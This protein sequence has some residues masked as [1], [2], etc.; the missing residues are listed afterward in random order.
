MGGGWLF[1]F[2]RYFVERKAE[3][4]VCLK[5]SVSCWAF[6]AILFR[7]SQRIECSSLVWHQKWYNYF[8][9]N[10]ASKKK[11]KV[12]PLSLGK[13]MILS[14]AK[15]LNFCGPIITRAK[16]KYTACGRLAASFVCLLVLS[17]VEKDVFWALFEVSCFIWSY[18]SCD[19]SSGEGMCELCWVLA[20]VLLWGCAAA[21]KIL[22]VPESSSR[23]GRRTQMG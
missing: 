7:Q 2:V 4:L 18:Q 6:D 15:A 23:C 22:A 11:K 5:V 1:L 21:C 20:A 3:H 17:A 19:C 9:N 14:K 13:T 12:V 8:M 10:P 16:Q